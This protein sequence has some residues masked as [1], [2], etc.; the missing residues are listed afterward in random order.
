MHSHKNLLYVNALSQWIHQ[1]KMEFHFK[2]ATLALQFNWKMQL[3]MFLVSFLFWISL[4]IC[5]IMPWVMISNQFKF[6]RTDVTH[7]EKYTQWL[8]GVFNLRIDDTASQIRLNHL[9]FPF[10]VIS[11]QCLLTKHRK[12][13]TIKTAFLKF[14]LSLSFRFGAKFVRVWDFLERK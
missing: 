13:C 14:S 11:L 7:V 1:M 10:P 3:T 2:F 12:P 9:G 6:N 8:I 5:L 4:K